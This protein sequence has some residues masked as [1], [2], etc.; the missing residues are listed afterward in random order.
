MIFNNCK[1]KQKLGP[2]AKPLSEEA[3]D[4]ATTDFWYKFLALESRKSLHSRRFY[5]GLPPPNH[6]VPANEVE[7]A[8]NYKVPKQ[9]LD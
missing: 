7:L 4:C 9:Q 2:K 6:A 3:L 5:Y 1:A 8:L